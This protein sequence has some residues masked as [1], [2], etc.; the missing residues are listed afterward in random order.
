MTRRRHTER[1]GLAFVM[2]DDA[3]RAAAR[4]LA[5]MRHQRRASPHTIAA[6]GRD[7]AHFG[8]FLRDHLGQP[9]DLAA[10]AAL[11]P[12]D[13]RAWMAH[14]RRAGDSARTLARRLSAVRGF[15]AWLKRHEGT[16]NPALGVLRGP[17]CKPLL[18]H[19]VPEAQAVALPARARQSRSGAPAWVRARD[20]AVLMLLYGC[21]LRVS[22]AL[23]I[24]A[25]QARDLVRGTDMLRVVGKGGKE[26]LVPV[27]TPVRAALERYL[28]TCP[29]VLRDDEPVFRGVRGGVLNARLVQRLMRELR[30]ALGLPDTATPHA[31]RHAFATD[32]LSHGADLRAI[33]EL[34]GHASLST[35]QIYAAVSVGELRAIHAR[36]HPRGGG[37]DG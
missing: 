21:G 27:M 23:A 2:A 4:Y 24:S 18:P 10:L 6:Y 14:A 16:D 8:R 9:A 33:Q 36:A 1:E 7:L 26:R 30:V 25:G 35:T 32:L 15:F 12:A 22:E 28:E 37:E 13:F 17:R 29:L 34:L 3:A 5:H 31:L 20:A 11:S 19:P